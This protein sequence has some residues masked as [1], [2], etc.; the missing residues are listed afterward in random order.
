MDLTVCHKQI[1]EEW[2]LQIIVVAKLTVNLA[3][4]RLVLT[5]KISRISTESL[6]HLNQTSI[7]ST[8]SLTTFSKLLGLECEK[9]D[10]RVVSKK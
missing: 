5:W 4:S 6:L 3:V 10:T 9:K 8:S 7:F 2:R 1:E